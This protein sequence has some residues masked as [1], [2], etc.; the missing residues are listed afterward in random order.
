MKKSAIGFLLTLSA[1]FAL[2]GA[3]CD[4]NTP[5]SSSQQSGTHTV[6]F[7]EGDG[8]TFSNTTVADGASVAHGSVA[9]FQLDVGAFLCR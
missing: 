8:Y 6:L 7:E 9:S 3:A 5:V 1:L 4:T 2:G